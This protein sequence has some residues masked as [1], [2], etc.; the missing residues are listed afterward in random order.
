MRNLS[1]LFPIKTIEEMESVNNAINEVNTNEYINAIKHLLKGDPEKHFEEI[2]SR[3]MCNEVNV[4]GFHGMIGLKKYTSLYDAIINDSQI[5]SE[6]NYSG[7]SNN[8][9]Y[10]NTNN[11]T[12]FPN[13]NSNNKTCERCKSLEAKIDDLNTKFDNMLDYLKKMMEVQAKQGAQLSVLANKDADMRNLSKLFPIKTIEE[14]E[15]VNNAINEVNINEY[16]N[17]IKH[18]LKGNPEKHFEEIISRTMCNEV[19]VGGF[20]GMIGLKKYTSLYDAIINDSQIHS[21]NNYSGSSNNNNYLNTNNNT[22]FP[23]S[24]SNNKTCERC[25]SLEAKIDDL[26]T[27]FDNMLEYLKKMMEVQAKQGAQLSVLANKD[28]DMRNLS[29]LFPIKTIEEMESVNNAINEVNI[30]EYI[31]AIK[32]LLKGDPEKHF[33]EIISR[34]MCNEVNVGG[35]HGMIGLKK[36]TSLYD[37]I[38]NDSQI[39]SENNYSGSSNTNNYLKTNNNTNFPNSNSNNKTCKSNSNNK[40]CKRCKSLEA[41]IDDLNT[42]FDNMLDYLKK[43]MEVQA[44]QGAQLSVLANKDAD[45]RNLSKLFPIKTIEEME[46]VNNAINEVNINEYI[47]AIKHLLKG[48]PEKHFEEIISRSTYVQRSQCNTRD[49]SKF[50]ELLRKANACDSFDTTSRNYDQKNIFTYEMLLS[51]TSMEI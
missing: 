48:D 33:E 8:N 14:M 50:N 6:N 19:N 37:A 36:Y 39:H 34:T 47:N 24:N 40:T 26:N 16:I 27:K 10:L 30:N 15:S 22:N 46:S 7:S 11:N 12:N 44:K 17:A 32:H 28:A 23:N 1:K 43:M 5:H 4:G 18:L 31:N 42:K 13:S 45:M 41:K 49:K 38:I 20:H 9:N 51:E 2:I 35:F 29:K 21:E 25:K 3:T